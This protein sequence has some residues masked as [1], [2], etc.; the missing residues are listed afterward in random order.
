[1]KVQI[2]IGSARKGRSTPLVANW[3]KQTADKVLADKA[4]IEQLALDN[5]KIKEFLADKKPARVIYVPGRLVN[6]VV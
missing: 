6:I 3:V 4:D 1:M 5:D 2:I